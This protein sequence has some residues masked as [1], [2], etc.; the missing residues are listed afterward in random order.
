M[1]ALCNRADHYNFAVWFLS[2][3][4]FFLLFSS[5]N[6]SGLRL[7]VYHTS[8]H[9]EASAN[10]ECRSEMCCTRLAE[11]TCRMQ[12]KLPLGHHRTTLSGYIFAT[13]AH[14]DNRK[15]LFSN[16]I[17]STY[18]HNTVKFGLLAAEIGW[19]V[20]GTGFASWQR[21][22]TTLQYWASAKLCGVEQRAPAIFGMAAIT[23]G[24]GPHF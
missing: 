13:K 24:I 3:S 5:P 21:Y 20:W 8:T 12:K 19:R 6:L 9:G 16:N 10:L 7:D 22:C 23:L 17:F 4:S 14:I 11:N 18:P 15:N 1:A 2:S